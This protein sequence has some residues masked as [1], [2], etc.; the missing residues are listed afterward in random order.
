MVV[1]VVVVVIAVIGSIDIP[2][3]AHFAHGGKSF[4]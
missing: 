2:L 4:G 3:T 1:V